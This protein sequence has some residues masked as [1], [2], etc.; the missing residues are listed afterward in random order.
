[1]SPANNA[2]FSRRRR[3]QLSARRI[4]SAG[5]AVKK[6][7]TSWPRLRPTRFTTWRN[8]P[9]AEY[10]ALTD[11][12]RL[13]QVKAVVNEKAKS[14]RLI[15]ILA[16]AGAVTHTAMAAAAE[17]ARTG[18][19]TAPATAAVGRLDASDAARLFSG[20]IPSL[21]HIDQM[22]T[23]HR[24][25]AECRS[26]W[27]QVQRKAIHKKPIA[28]SYNTILANAKRAGISTADL[29]KTLATFLKNQGRIPNQKYITIVDFRKNSGQKRLFT[30][31][32]QTGQVSGFV[33]SAGKG[34]DPDH[35]GYAT[36][37]SNAGG[38]NAS[39]LG[40]AIA[41]GNY[42]GKHGN[43]LM[44]H[45]F[46]SSNDRMCD[47]RI[48]IHKTESYAA[49]YGRSNGCLAI[50]PADRN[51]ILSRTGGGGLI[52]SFG[53]SSGHAAPVKKTAKAKKHGKKHVAKATH[54]HTVKHGK[55]S[56]KHAK[57]HK[58]KKKVGR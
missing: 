37:F 51:T 21:S 1:M 38:S 32:L 58:S 31:D 23:S 46:E 20:A 36:H 29:N 45:G 35:D 44:L 24:V 55:H 28:A 39:S 53:S 8:V 2:P 30:I 11:G 10:N 42:S 56:A 57:K 7:D 49:G 50:R 40:C 9:E 43:S 27:R 26:A 13:A 18:S 4:S 22:Y 52:C 6:A 33:V 3:R 25:L 54:K 41:A 16:L 47:R 15:M 5:G 48:V 14:N 34:S 17:I 12:L 19:D